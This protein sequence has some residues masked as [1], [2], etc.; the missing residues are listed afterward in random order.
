M[1]RGWIRPA[2]FHDKYGVDVSRRF[3]EP[4]RSL[5]DEGLA[6]INADRI[7]LTREALLKVDTLLP[8][9]FLPGHVGI[10]YT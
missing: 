6:A 8:R 2:Y 5:R 4:L 3:A 1:K 10:R 9:F 7:T